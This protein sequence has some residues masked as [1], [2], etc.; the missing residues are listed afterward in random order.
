MKIKYLL[1]LIPL[2][3][4]FNVLAG[5][6][7]N[8]ELI[9]SDD[10]ANNNSFVFGGSYGSFN[11]TW[12]DNNFQTNVLNYV[13]THL[14][15]T[16]RKYYLTIP[17][18]RKIYD[19]T[20]YQ[21]SISY[22]TFYFDQTDIDN[23]IVIN[24]YAFKNPYSGD[25]SFALY[26]PNANASS[27][28]NNDTLWNHFFNDS[29]EAS[30]VLLRNTNNVSSPYT[31]YLPSN[32]YVSSNIPTSYNSH[33][34]FYY[35]VLGYP[36]DWYKGIILNGITYPYNSQS[37]LLNSL[38]NLTV[39]SD[40]I[41]PII[42]LDQDLDIDIYNVD[43]IDNFKESTVNCIDNLDGIVTPFIDGTYDL[44]KEGIYDIKYSCT[45]S[46]FNTSTLTQT[47]SVHYDHTKLFL[48]L[49]DIF[50]PDTSA[51]Y[52]TFYPK[53][54]SS[55]SYAG[56]MFKFNGTYDYL[57]HDISSTP[58]INNFYKADI[59]TLFKDP[60]ILKNISNFIFTNLF[61]T[62]YID[63]TD[64]IIKIINLNGV[65]YKYPAIT[66]HRL[67]SN[68]SGITFSCTWNK[69]YIVY[70]S[71]L[72]EYNTFNW[73]YQPLDG[74]FKIDTDADNIPDTPSFNYIDENNNN[75]TIDNTDLI[76]DYNDML[77]S[78]KNA[79]D[80]IESVR[81]SGSILSNSISKFFEIVDNLYDMLP[82]YLVSILGFILAIILVISIIAIFM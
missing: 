51:S 73:L 49:D 57:Q 59:E 47:I 72:L 53:T 69:N 32:L 10:W 11:Q 41:P 19:T 40:N 74:S 18:P 75:I 56:L 81:D 8:Y 24:L 46:S 78:L 58:L 68:C 60:L 29:P 9:L 22:Q 48:D 27:Q 66:F 65:S 23:D 82:N 7:D 50:D 28:D 42:T 76:T 37:Y 54:Y 61:V 38:D 17:F 2:F 13:N 35:Y 43:D 64:P 45:D 67:S 44:Y 77:K 20:S 16:T 55:I 79:K 4:G 15:D 1:L 31:F 62:Q 5:D 70:N 25:A 12:H 39:P 3:F 71:S 34:K 21:N 6:Q 33:F 30:N 52:I 26:I 36:T 63:V 14:N 80:L